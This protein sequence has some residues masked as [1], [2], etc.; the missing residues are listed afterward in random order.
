MRAQGL[1]TTPTPAVIT[2]TNGSMPSSQNGAV[3][4]TATS[5]APSLRSS[6]PQQA[7]PPSVA[8]SALRGLF[9]ANRPRSPSG[10]TLDTSFG[11]I[12]ERGSGAET[13]PP[14][15][16]SFGRAGTSLLGML[17]SN[18]IS[19]ERP[20]SPTTPMSSSPSTPRVGHPTPAD[21]PIQMGLIS[22]PQPV[23]TL[24]QK[25]LQDRDRESILPTFSR[26]G[27]S[28][29]GLSGL[30]G[31]ANG[32]ASRFNGNGLPTFGGSASLQPPPRR[33]AWTASGPPP[34]TTRTSSD[35]NGF[36][37]THGNA[38]AAET[39][40]VRHNGSAF[41]SPK[42]SSPAPSASP[43]PSPASPSTTSSPKFS[44]SPSSSPS[45]S[46]R[47]NGIG[48]PASHTSHH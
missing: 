4:P 22:P 42:A 46:G 39:L 47:E 16:A 40:G 21:L 38:S 15:E 7:R 13:P 3:S 33:R 6:S 30:N 8:V 41:L 45:P 31:H 18:S 9:G 1:F 43:S 23:P 35:R 24:D 25:I 11:S 19:S 20:L 12:A 48:S 37:Y 32:S 17:R 5:P 27:L 14:E 44:P 36:A 29:L 10:A 2:S 34:S 26:N 28:G